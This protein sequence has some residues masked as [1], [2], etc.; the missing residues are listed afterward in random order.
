M[1][2]AVTIPLTFTANVLVETLT[3]RQVPVLANLVAV[4]AAGVAATT[5]LVARIHE[6]SDAL[7]EQA[8][9]RLERLEECVGDY[10]AGFA[11]GY[12]LSVDRDPATVVP[13]VPSGRFHRAVAD[14]RR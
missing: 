14:R 5:A 11:A 7:T 2:A 10:N 1:F 13:L 12:L 8:L 4:A 3:N 6:R 9:A